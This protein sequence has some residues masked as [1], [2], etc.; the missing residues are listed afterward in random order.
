GNVDMQQDGTPLGSS[1]ATSQVGADRRSID[2]EAT[3]RTDGTSGLSARLNAFRGEPLQPVRTTVRYVPGSGTAQTISVAGPPARVT[4]DPALLDAAQ[5]FVARALTAVL[6]FGDR[7]LMLAC[8]LVPARTARDVARVIATL[9]TAQAA[10]MV[11]SALGFNLL[12]PALPVTAMVAS[13][14]IV[15]AAV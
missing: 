14:V 7:L 1:G 6:A 2:I 3:Y 9:I 4:F 13:S 5:E 11:G 12:A 15:V 8:L 10:G